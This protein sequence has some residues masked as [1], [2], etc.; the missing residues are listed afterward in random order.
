[1][2]VGVAMSIGD[3]VGIIVFKSGS[4]MKGGCLGVGGCRGS[5]VVEE[6]ESVSEW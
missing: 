4:E 3:V 5:E 2:R 1:L 6:G